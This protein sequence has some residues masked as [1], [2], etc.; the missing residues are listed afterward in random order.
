MLDAGGEAQDEVGSPR[1]VL[2]PGDGPFG[3]VH[4]G[5]LHFGQRGQEGGQARA[6]LRLAQVEETAH[7]R[8]TER[9]N[10]VRKPSVCIR[11]TLPMIVCTLLPNGQVLVTGG[12]NGSSAVSSAELYD[13]ATGGWTS[14]GRMSTPRHH[15]TATPW[16]AQK[17][18]VLERR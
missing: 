10:F 3:P 4:D 18:F 15:H 5:F 8:R 9:R 1:L 14:T 7:Q 12:H 2:W 13:P 6:D 11:F 16:I 17:Y